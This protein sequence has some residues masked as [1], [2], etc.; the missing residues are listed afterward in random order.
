L[1]TT[2]GRRNTLLHETQPDIYAHDQRFF[3][4]RGSLRQGTYEVCDKGDIVRRISWIQTRDR[5]WGSAESTDNGVNPG[6]RVTLAKD[7]ASVVRRISKSSEH[8]VKLCTD[9]ALL[10]QICWMK[11]KPLFRLDWYE[12]AVYRVSEVGEFGIGTHQRQARAQ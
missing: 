9:F 2:R 11:R 10:A 4:G 5:P 8:G 12:T 1:Q 7:E 6:S 3:S